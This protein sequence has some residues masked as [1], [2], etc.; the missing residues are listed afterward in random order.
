MR[1]R[2]GWLSFVRFLQWGDEHDAVPAAARRIFARPL[3]PDAGYRA[4]R[5]PRFLVQRHPSQRDRGE[6]RSGRGIVAQ[7]QCDGRSD[8]R[9]PQHHVPPRHRRAARQCRSR[10]RELALAA[11]RAYAMSGVVLNPHYRGMGELY[12][13]EYWTYTLPRRVGRTRAIELTQACQPLGAMAARE[14][15]LLDDAFGEDAS[16]FEAELRARATRLAQDPDFRAMLRENTSAASTTKDKPLACYR[17]EES[18][19]MKVNFFGPDPAY[20][21]ARRRFVFRAPRHH[22]AARRFRRGSTRRRG[23]SEK[24]QPDQR[25]RMS[26]GP[27]RSGAPMALHT[28]RNWKG[29]RAQPLMGHGER[30]CW[31]CSAGR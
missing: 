22:R 31:E 9:D 23:C 8:P 14:M 16:S 15:G 18:E 6:R 25:R 11:D 29:A 13:S 27:L 20:H 7:H 12:G 30:A 21:K 3:T 2:T 10:R 4:F 26:V 5:R 1:R 19:R 24:P 17:A 28:L